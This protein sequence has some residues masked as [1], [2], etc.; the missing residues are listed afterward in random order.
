MI[1]RRK[2][3]L[4]GNVQRLFLGNAR[5]AHGKLLDFFLF[6]IFLYI[7]EFEDSWISLQ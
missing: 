5:D 2:L 6:L 4:F 3:V 7:F 1:V